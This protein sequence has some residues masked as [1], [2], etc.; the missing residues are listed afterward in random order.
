VS[1]SGLTPEELQVG[2]DEDAFYGK[3]YWLS[4]MGEE[5]KGFPNIV[6]RARGELIERNLYWSRTI[7][8]LKRP[9]A[10]ILELGC[11]HG[12]LLALLHEAG[13]DATGIE[14]SPWVCQFASTTF[15]VPVLCGPVEEQGLP[16]GTFDG[17][18][19][20]D[21][22]EHLPE[23]VKT[24]QECVRLLKPDGFI[25][26]QTPCHAPGR[27][28]AQLQAA[29][30]PF[31]NMLLPR[32]HVFIFTEASARKLF[33][34]L[35]LP[36]VQTFTAIFADYDMYFAVSR[37]ALAVGSE[38]EISEALLK[39]RRQR[40]VLALM[41]L[42]TEYTAAV[43]ALRASETDRWAR[44]V[45]INELMERVAAMSKGWT[46]MP[47]VVQRLVRAIAARS[48]GTK[49]DE[50]TR[51]AG[52]IETLR[53][54]NRSLGDEKFKLKM[55]LD[56]AEK[57]RAA[58]LEQNRAL[59]A[60]IEKLRGDV[61]SVDAERSKLEAA[62]QDMAATAEEQRQSLLD[63]AKALQQSMAQREQ[64]DALLRDSEA[65]RAAR[66]EQIQTLTGWLLQERER[67]I[68]TAPARPVRRVV[69]DL[70]PLLPGA[71]N[72]GAKPMT[73]ELLKRMSHRSPQTRFILLTL[74]RTFK[75]L[76]AL[77]R[78][79]VSRVLIDPS[80]DPYPVRA[81]RLLTR[82]AP[83]RIRR[84]L[85]RRTQAVW[86]K[87]RP[88][89]EDEDAAGRIGGSVLFC[90][91][92]APFFARE[93]TPTVS[94]IYDLQY[95]DYPQYFDEQDRWQRERNFTE[96]CQRADKLVCISDFV[97]QRVIKQSGLPAERVT[98]I[99]IQLA[100]RLPVALPDVTASLLQRL[101]LASARYLLY[102]AN[103]WKHKNHEMLL[104]AFG[105][106]AARHPDSD[107][108]LVLTGA[109]DER[110]EFIRE[111]VGRMG[112][113]ARVIFP[114]FLS[115]PEF[116]ALI[117]ECLAVIYPS[118]YEGFGM[119]LIEAQAVGKPVLCSDRAS[120][121]EVAGDSA[122]TFDPRLPETIATAIQRIESDSALREQL[123]KKGYENAKRF[124]DVDA[125][126]DQY[127]KV[128][129]DEVY[130][131]SKPQPNAAHG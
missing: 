33:S 61:S 39:S 95:A 44:L 90:P 76:S 108:K 77:D 11:S 65:D 52:E 40:M 78:P 84:G 112:L 6:E 63:A 80:L 94:V 74:K 85:E 56:A 113:S 72:G 16:A 58:R 98:A 131:A 114:G 100:S 121:P 26:V 118:L 15:G 86:S 29:Q 105:L 37:K 31:L 55:A 27:S 8:A 13:Y 2:S 66:L 35:G 22:L 28:L 38:A 43:Q 83:D 18:V 69:V 117:N 21:V 102:P 103:F 130:G 1:T 53:I 99:H 122:L 93:G 60:E 127:L 19:L 67:G 88:L 101:Q 41:D 20:M 120:L 30:H 9:P 129:A 7:L 115:E 75:E 42:G 96:A 68:G 25:L 47:G 97:R 24:M 46:W 125:M 49:Q 3:E 71:A 70:T 126:A 119:P 107:L 57:D 124:E 34:A 17:I 79:N 82:H 104:V 87:I 110:Q 10:K 91:F 116:A 48:S 92:T 51:L 106:Y 36:H 109:P 62:L 128:L 64:L 14:L 50:A 45:A 32:E 5:G 23:P 12:G 81:V 54:V 4:R 123:V 111:A 89:L 59:V 73:L